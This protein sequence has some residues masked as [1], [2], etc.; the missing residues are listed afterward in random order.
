[1]KAPEQYRIKT[2]PMAS[3]ESYGNNGCFIIPY[4]S[5]MLN[6]IASDGQGWEHVS[7]SL[8]GR[9]PNWSEMCFVKDLFWHENDCVVQF[10]PPKREYVNNHP[11]C[12]HLWKQIG[13]QI[14]TP[15]TLLVGI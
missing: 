4:Q 11:N 7:V 3:D 15:P 5:F 10:H 13:K 9:T 6:V 8:P 14:E 1:M 12:L 2:G